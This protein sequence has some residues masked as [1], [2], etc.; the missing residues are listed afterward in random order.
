LK[1]E[2]VLLID[3]KHAGGKELKTTWKFI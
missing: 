2:G 3:E 1:K